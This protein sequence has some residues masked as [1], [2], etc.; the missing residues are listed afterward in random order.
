LNIQVTKEAHDNLVQLG[1]DHTTFLRLGVKSGGCS[2]MTYDARLD[3]ELHAG[4]QIVYHEPP[5][6]IVAQRDQ[7]ALLNG[8]SIDYSTDLVRSG[9]RLSNP[10]NAQSCGCGASFK[11]GAG[12][13]TGCG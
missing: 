13:G 11:S 4:D 9:F 7:A 10:N 6:R 8:L 1:L 2:G 3:R 12:C 5:V